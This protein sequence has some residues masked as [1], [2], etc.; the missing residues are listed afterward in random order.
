MCVVCVDLY[1][2]GLGRQ[3]PGPPWLSPRGAPGRRAPRSPT[4]P[5]ARDPGHAPQGRASRARDHG[6]ALRERAHPRGP[7]VPRQASGV[8]ARRAERPRDRGRDP[9]DALRRGG[10]SPSQ[11]PARLAVDHEADVAREQTAEPPQRHH[12]QECADCLEGV[13][14]LLATALAFLSLSPQLAFRAGRPERARRHAVREGR[15]VLVGV[16]PEGLEGLLRVGHPLLSAIVG[17]GAM[18]SP[19]ERDLLAHG[20]CPAGVPELSV[21]RTGSLAFSG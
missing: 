4:P 16:P 17:T 13:R 20:T 8:A 3:A 5:R 6:L 10:H 12:E 7:G 1:D 18:T 11:H 14:R 15:A 2:Q 21:G 19:S 9:R